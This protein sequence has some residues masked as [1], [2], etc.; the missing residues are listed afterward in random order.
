MT[1]WLLG[2]ILWGGEEKRRVGLDCDLRGRGLCLCLVPVSWTPQA[3]HDDNLPE[4][5]TPAYRS[6]FCR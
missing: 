1:E 5:W 3:Y 6:Y 2:R 4:S